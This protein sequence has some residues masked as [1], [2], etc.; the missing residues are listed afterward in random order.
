MTPAHI[1]PQRLRQRM[2]DLGTIGRGDS[3]GI[4]RP[5]FSPAHVEAVRLVAQMMHE[6]G[7]DPGVDDFGNLI[8]HGV[9]GNGPL[10]LTGSH[11]DTVP[12]GGMFDGALGIV[13]AV[14]AAQTLRDADRR[15]RHPLA[16]IAFA[17]EEGYA[18]DIGTLS[19][20]ALVGEIPWSRFATLHDRS[21]Q[22]FEAY[23]RT[24]SHG[25]PVARVPERVGAYVEL[26][27]E[28][29]PVLERMG[30]AV[31]AV[32][33]ITGI[34]RT[35]VTF[36]GRA[37]HGGTTPMTAR[38]DALVG[39][40]ELV[41]AVR[42]LALRLKDRAVAT[43][44]RLSVHPGATNVIPGHVDLSVE[45]RSPD[46]RAL[47][48]LRAAVEQRSQMIADQQRLRVTVGSWDRSPPVPMDPGVRDAVVRALQ[49]CG[50]PALTLPSWAGHDAAV[51]ARYIPAGM[52][53]VASTAGLSH[54][55]REHTP[56]EIAAIGAQV[57]LETLVILDHATDPPGR[58][59]VAYALR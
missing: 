5:P 22:S 27:V 28:Q 47:D 56:W 45:V 14:E 20:R 26:H 6:A 36:K 54:S 23:L 9:G 38:A 8:G 43:V 10:L 1:S 59:P 46:E 25:L 51:L 42:E 37:A 58:L 21:G 34:L 7:L 12:D 50:Q 24:R 16:V 18:F 33:S 19:S 40:A 30:R 29:G 39:A 4:S 13:A 11:L 17:D 31:A 49:A 32:E 57:L 2:E 35:M 15:L 44:G 52:I 48:D 3:G 55:P 41:V 53:F